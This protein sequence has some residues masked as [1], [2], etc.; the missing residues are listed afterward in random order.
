MR[1]LRNDSKFHNKYALIISGRSGEKFVKIG[2]QK[3]KI[4]E[5]FKVNH[6]VF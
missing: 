3:L 5:K 2:Q 6:A 4:S 1:W